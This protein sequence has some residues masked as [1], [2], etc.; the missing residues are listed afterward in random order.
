MDVD[1]DGRSFPVINF[2]V[3]DEKTTE[4]FDQFS[5]IFA[6]FGLAFVYVMRCEH[7]SYMCVRCARERSNL[8]SLSFLS[9]SVYPSTFISFACQIK[10]NSGYVR[11][12]FLEQHLNKTL[13]IIL[14]DIMISCV[15]GGNSPPSMLSHGSRLLI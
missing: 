13:L 9:I 4:N 2:K 8:E 11:V 14:I 5:V 10:G 1:A 12:F 6:S 15:T 3:I 7:F